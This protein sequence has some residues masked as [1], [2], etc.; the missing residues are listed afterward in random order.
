MTDKKKTIGRLARGFG[1]RT[2]VTARLASKLGAKALR[3]LAT[4]DHKGKD[5]E[6]KAVAA[7]NRLLDELDGMKGL[8][9][10]FGQMAS[11]LEGSMPPAAQQVLSRLQAQSTPMAFDAIEAVVRAELDLE[12]DAAFEDFQRAPFAAASIG[13][14]HRARFEGGDVA[15][16]VQYPEIRDALRSD[17]KTVGLISKLGMAFGPISGGELAKEL[18]ERITEECDYRVE[19]KNQTLFAA[20]YADLDGASVPAV[21]PARSS[22]RVITSVLD[23]G[24]S[25]DAFLEQ[26]QSV[27]DRAGALIFEAC[28]RSI[29]VNAIYNADPHP[30]NYLFAEDGSVTFL[31]FGCVKRFETEFIDIWKGVARSVIDDDRARFERLFLGMVGKARGF[32]FD[33]QWEVMRYL[34]APF[35]AEDGTFAYT[36]EYVAESWDC[37]VWKNPNKLK[38]GMPR[39]WL[40]LNRLQWGLNSVLAMLGATGPW[41]T[42]WRAAVEAPTD[43]A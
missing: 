24:M 17:L 36:H 25:F 20:L 6:A 38:L 21:V 5:D 27:R 12:V 34:Y 26:P 28:F 9:M 14:V 33:Y 4:P 15:V 10:K 30:G 41:S 35:L 23:P 42:I 37:L 13:Q 2:L 32:D 43:P 40:F 29:F 3:K 1:G 18:S 31:D 22:E 39:D 8:L 16:K 19:A 11:Y 7:A